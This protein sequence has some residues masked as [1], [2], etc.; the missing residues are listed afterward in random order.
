[1]H[2]CK[3]RRW[4]ENSID[5]DLY[6]GWHKRELHANSRRTWRAQRRETRF[7]I[8]HTPDG[9]YISSLFI[10]TCD[11]YKEELMEELREHH[12]NDLLGY[13]RFDTTNSHPCMNIQVHADSCF[14][15]TLFRSFDRMKKV[16]VTA[17]VIYF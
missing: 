2:A 5:T 10:A 17:Q 4:Q 7:R 6:S 11:S 15:C 13:M 3:V 14:Y 12:P 8:C 1:M 16:F 9:Y